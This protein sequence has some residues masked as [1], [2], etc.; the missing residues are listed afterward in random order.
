M[1][2][3]IASSRRNPF[4]LQ[5]NSNLREL[6]LVDGGVEVS[7]S[8]LTSGQFQHHLSSCKA[9][10]G[11]GVAIPSY[12]RSIPTQAEKEAKEKA[13]REGRNP[14]LLQVNSNPVLGKLKE[15]LDLHSRNPFLLQVNSNLSNIGPQR[16]TEFGRNPFLLQVN[17]N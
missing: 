14:F 1:G 5:V 4:L 15:A 8:L 3:L 6:G 17:S 7:Q 2:W 13:E 16:Y 11:S 10:R 12:F 9:G